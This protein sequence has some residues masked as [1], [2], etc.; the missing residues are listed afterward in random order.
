MWLKRINRQ[1]ESKIPS[2]NG[3]RLLRRPSTTY[4]K[5]LGRVRF[6]IHTLAKAQS[7]RGVSHQ[8]AFMDSCLLLT[9]VWPVYLVDELSWVFYK[10]LLDRVAHGIVSN[11]NNSGSTLWQS[12]EHLEI[13]G[14]MIKMLMVFFQVWWVGVVVS[15][16][17]SW[18]YS[19]EFLWNLVTKLFCHVPGKWNVMQIAHS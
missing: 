8:P 7:A 6:G 5:L 18:S 14:L 17:G 11:F 12:V 1:G 19:K 3:G 15:S 16:L 9:H 2:I 13:I 4:E 10:K